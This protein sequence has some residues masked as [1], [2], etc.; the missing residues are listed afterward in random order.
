MWHMGTRSKAFPDPNAVVGG[1]AIR[2]RQ[3]CHQV[4]N[5]REPAFYVKTIFVSRRS[6]VGYGEDS[7]PQPLTGG[8]WEYADSGHWLD[9]PSMSAVGGQD[10]PGV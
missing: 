5:Q 6:G 9:S 3:G 8:R 7:A 10:A 2:F 4:S 1:A